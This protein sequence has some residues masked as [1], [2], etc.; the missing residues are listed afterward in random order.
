M[1]RFLPWAS[2]DSIFL[3]M[4]RWTCGTAPGPLVR[5][6][7]TERPTR[8]GRR[9]VAVRRSVSPSGTAQHQPAVAGQEARRDQPLAEGRLPDRHP[10]DLRDG[11][12][13]DAVVGEEPVERAR[14][15]KRRLRIVGGR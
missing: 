7:V 5:A 13:A 14:G 1:S 3:P 6:A 4:R 10:V 2:T 15:Q 11:Q 9:P 12:L 8:Y